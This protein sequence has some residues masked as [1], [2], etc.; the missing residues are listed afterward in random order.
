MQDL[1]LAIVTGAG[2]GIGKSIAATLAQANWKVVVNDINQTT[3]KQTAD[4]INCAGKA[5]AMHGDISDESTVAQIFHQIEKDI[6]NSPALLVN[7]AGIQT[8]APLSELSVNDWQKTLATNLTGCFLMCKFFAA[9]APANSSII[10]IGSGC[11]SLAFPNLIDYSASKGGIEMF[12]KSIALDLGPRGI[13]VNCIAPG[14]IA[15]ERTAAET[16]DY[17]NRWAELTPLRRVGTPQDVANAVLL[18]TDEKAS[19][20]SGQTIKVDGGLFSRAAWPAE[21]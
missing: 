13:R 6:A 7:N 1:P 5:I 16:H 17:S 20:I 2:S 10:N 18:L 19:F 21:Y 14:A 9:L 12:T 4:E 3:V 8:W 15:T 11:N